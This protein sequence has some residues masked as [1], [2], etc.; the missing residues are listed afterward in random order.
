MKQQKQLY[1]QIDPQLYYLLQNY[2][3]RTGKSIR[4][5]IEEALQLLFE[6]DRKRKRLTGKALVE[7]LKKYMHDT[8]E[9]EDIVS[10]IDEIVY[11]PF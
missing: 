6:K 8:G 9:K 7:E 3:Q 11:G 2:K 10:K 4:Q 5:I 1:A